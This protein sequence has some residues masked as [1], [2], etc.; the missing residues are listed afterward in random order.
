MTNATAITLT[1]AERTLV[2]TIFTETIDSATM[3]ASL[4]SSANGHTAR[5]E[6]IIKKA[7][8]A[9]GIIVTTPDRG[10]GEF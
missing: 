2:T 8:R 1:T 9:R 5:E 6:R 4:I 7:L 10:I 3:R